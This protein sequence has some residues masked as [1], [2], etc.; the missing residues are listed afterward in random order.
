MHEKLF[1]LIMDPVLT[2]HDTTTFRVKFA[3]ADTQ[4]NQFHYSIY[5][6]FI[7]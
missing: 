3:I 7:I 1:Y 5:I 6:H 4:V 2:S